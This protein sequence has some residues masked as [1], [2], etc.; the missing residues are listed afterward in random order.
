[1]LVIC[2]FTFGCHFCREESVQIVSM[3]FFSLEAIAIDRRTW[4]CKCPKLSFGWTFSLFLSLTQ[5]SE[6]ARLLPREAGVAFQPFVILPLVAV[7]V[8]HAVTV[9]LLEGVVPAI[10]RVRQHRRGFVLTCS[11]C[12]MS[13]TSVVAQAVMHF[14]RSEPAKE[15]MKTP[16]HLMVL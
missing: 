11:I 5:E 14:L 9:C 1:M 15:S 10:L 12:K 8:Q 3:T 4:V 6:P 7:L 16:L 2:L 13:L